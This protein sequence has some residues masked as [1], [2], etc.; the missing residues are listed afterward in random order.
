MADRFCRNCGHEL[1][2][3][4][5]FCTNC[6]TRVQQ[7]AHVPTPEAGTAAPQSPPIQQAGGTVGS[8]RGRV[9]AGPYWIAFAVF[10]VA[11]LA[12]GD[13]GTFIALVGV[14]LATAW[15]YQ[16]ASSRGMENA[17]TWAV[18]VFLLFIVFFP[19]YFFKRRPRSVG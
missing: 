13:S 2:E 3:G 16:D 9:R 14:I 18:G 8:E 10:A 6:G 12:M 17:G 15:V 11:A 5:R 1:A 19:L 4:V 7:A